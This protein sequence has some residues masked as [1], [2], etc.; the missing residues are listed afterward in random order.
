M[1][2]KRKASGEAG[3]GRNRRT[4]AATGFV[5]DS[6]SS[7]EDEVKEEPSA[8]SSMPPPPEFAASSSGTSTSR[9]K[10]ERRPGTHFEWD[11]TYVP[12]DASSTLAAPSELESVSADTGVFVG[13]EEKF[14]PFKPKR[15]QGASIALNAVLPLMPEIQAEILRTFMHP[16]QGSRCDCNKAPATF[17]CVDC[18]NAPMWCRECI[19]RKHQYTPFHHIEK[20]DGKMFARTAPLGT[21]TPVEGPEK[22][23]PKLTLQT[24]LNHGVEKCPNAHPERPSIHEFT[25]GDHN[26]FHTMDIQFCECGGNI[27][28]DRWRQLV[29]VR[30]FP[31]TFKQPQTAFTFTAMKQFHIHSLTSKKS[32]YNYVRA[33]AKLTD[34][35][36]PQIVKDRYREFLFAL[37]IWRYLALERRSG[38]AHGIDVDVPHRRPGSLTLWCPPCPE[39]EFNI[40]AEM[41]ASAAETERHKFTWFVLV[42]GNFKLQRKNKRDD[43]D[44]Y[45]LNGGIGYFVETEEYKAYLKVA[46][47]VEELGTC[48][49]LRAARMQNIG[50]FKNAVVSGVVAVQCARHG[51]YLPQGMVDLTK[52]EAFANTDYA[53]VFSVAE[54]A[55][56]RWIHLTYDIWCQ[57]GI[58]F[59]ERVEEMFPSMSGIAAKIRGA[60]PKMHILN[61][62]ER[63]QLEWN[64]NWLLY[65]AFTIGEMIETGWAEHNLTAGSTKEM[66]AGH[67]H[68]AVDNTSNHWNWDKMISLAET[69]VRL[70][71]LAVSERRSRTTNFDA[72]DAMWRDQLP[73][74]LAKWEKMDVTPRFVDG[75]FYSVF[76]ATFKKGP[77]T[78]AEAYAKLLNAERNVE[79]E[80]SREGDVGLI[81]YGLLAERDRA[82]IKR[83]ITMSAEPHVLK[84][85][86][87][88]LFAHIAALRTLQI[89]RV[90]QF[91]K[92]MMEVD[93]DKPEDTPLFLPSQ[94]SDSARVEMK[95]EALALVEYTLREGQAYDALQDLRTAIRTFNYNLRVKM[96]DIHGVHGNTRA[97]NYLKTLSNDIQVA[98]DT[99][100]R[101][102]T[103]LLQLGLS[104]DDP[105]L[106]VLE[107]N[108]L[109]GKGGQAMK[110]GHAREVEPWFWSVAR[111]AGLSKEEEQEWETER[112]SFLLLAL[113]IADTFTQ[114][115]GSS[116]FE[117]ARTGTVQ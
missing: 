23:E 15:F 57:Y 101:A 103:A 73:E 71:R 32:A 76:Q 90:P 33:L 40:T 114:W 54:A 68:D 10:A 51:F 55:R 85:A 8:E 56:L 44:D 48:S 111:P 5:V 70:Y 87:A 53:V 95:L 66:N 107:A 72:V 7:E 14:G 83:M 92:H 9:Q 115:T 89:Q 4:Q 77:P 42:D 38:Q 105:T 94:F 22:L 112:E 37:R 109:R 104:S 69:L 117:I 3:T 80:T 1:S 93:P 67:R 62:I 116:G 20:W 12:P 96:T 78:H 24:E 113:P 41:M 13:T 21:S 30:L 108:T 35:T 75:K 84:A 58:H 59:T 6:D 99:Y 97:Q 50:K 34:N 88:R 26:G 49:H 82:H 27:T 110:L 36:R 29:A 61:H 86:R 2:R 106:K 79:E 11:T 65:V 18:F 64:L 81:D 91:S 19:I 46:R 47:P 100:R 74:E 102:R 45:A 60:I 63:C 98:G 25:I 52:G 28:A 31:A 39:V 16:D 43:P 17:R